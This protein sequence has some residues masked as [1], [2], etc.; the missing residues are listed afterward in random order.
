VFLTLGVALAAA[1]LVLLTLGSAKS[2]MFS[3]NF[4]LLLALAGGVAAAL[5][6]LVGVLL[7]RLRRSL[8]QGIFG[9]KLSLRL[10][11]MFGLMALLPG[12][13]V[14]ALS[15][16]FLEKTI[17]SWFDVRVDHALQSGV[18]L[19]RSTLDSLLADLARKA[20]SMGYTLSEEP[21]SMQ[22][23]SL[24]RL[25]EQAAVAEAVLVTSRGRLIGF[26]GAE[27]MKLTPELPDL[28]L[29]GLDG[30]FARIESGAGDALLLKAIV[31]VHSLTL[32]D[33]DRYLMLVQPVAES[34]A[35]DAQAV[36]DAFGEYQ[37]ITVSRLGLKRMFGFT[38]T[39]ALLI[40]LLLALVLAFYLSERMGAPLRALVRGTRAIA[41]GDFSQMQ[42]VES[43]DELGLVIHS[44]NRM[45]RQLAEAREVA[46]RHQARVG[47]A[48]AYLEQVLTHLASGVLT[49][50]DD[51]RVRTLNPRALEILGL[52]RVDAR[53][54]ELDRIEGAPEGLAAL[55]RA[56]REHLA[57]HIVGDWET[58]LDYLGPVGMQTLLLRGTR[59]PSLDAS[60]MLVFD[61]ITHLIRAERDA[62]WGEVA[63]R[64]AHEIRN[65]LTPIQLSAE[66]MRHKLAAH[67]SPENAA[68]LDRATQTIVNQVASMKGMVEAFANYAKLPRA[69]L[70][71]LDLNALVHEVV[72]LYE[73]QVDGLELRFGEDLPRVIADAALLRQIIHNLLLNAQDALSGRAEP[74]ILI[75]TRARGASVALLVSD[76]G[77]GFPEHL[78][79]RLFEPYATTKAKGTGLGLA[80]VKKIVEEHHGGI[81]V[82]NIEG[83]GARVAVLLPVAQTSPREQ[84]Q[85]REAMG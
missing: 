3:E 49:L 21:P 41:K 64:L 81:E 15:V 78:M 34:V 5:G 82:T 69:K 30:R 63:R 19:G 25:R 43:R 46:D 72:T 75:E 36:Q 67:L 55:A 18:S 58:Q 1:I 57:D 44:F 56:V 76:N 74:H 52:E 16:H 23:S 32:A 48:K 54:I 35:R 68:F 79:P 50:D 66:R 22:V 71:P 53:D 11:W 2:E 70:A 65:P 45:T 59:L 29:L 51:L 12:A 4:P 20:D 26:A 38:L 17:D 73:Q 28:S 47:E 37:A 61:D 40:I 24:D 62:A 33:D 31:P 83:G 39:L 14:Y 10:V 6:V 80:V 13:V 9:A 77:P 42:P 84:D 85:P 60:V 7:W 27:R 8:R